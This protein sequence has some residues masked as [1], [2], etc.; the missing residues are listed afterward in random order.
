MKTVLSWLMSLI[1]VL[2]ILQ[3]VVYV[4]FTMVK[5]PVITTVHYVLL[6][7][8]RIWLAR[9]VTDDSLRKMVMSDRPMFIQTIHRHRARIYAA[10]FVIH[11]TSGAISTW[12]AFVSAG[13][14]RR[15]FS[16]L[17]LPAAAAGQSEEPEDVARTIVD[18]H[19]TILYMYG[20]ASCAIAS[21]LNLCEIYYAALNE[22][23]LDVAGYY[24]NGRRWRDW[25]GVIADA[26]FGRRAPGNRADTRYS[27]DVV[28]LDLATII[29]YDGPYGY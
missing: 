26:V 22:K 20:I 8:A 16:V 10:I 7:L 24:G 12:N 27:V 29:A 9:R 4:P 1:Y 21:F 5:K 25:L 14:A 15:M 17:L 3:I 23:R 19:L 18:F 2:Q 11:C 13:Y 6:P 28:H